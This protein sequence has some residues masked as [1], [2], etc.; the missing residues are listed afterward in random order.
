LA[1]ADLQIEAVQILHV[2]ALEAL[3]VVVSYGIQAASTQLLFDGFRV[4]RLDGKPVPLHDGTHRSASP[5]TTT[6]A[7][8]RRCRKRIGW[9]LPKNGG[10][11]VAHVHH[12]A[13]PVV[14]PEL[15]PHQRRIEC[16]FLLRL[17]DPERDVI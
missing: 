5:A 7:G 2:K 9:H 8:R 17:R 11:P 6:T 4:P 12:N 1:I 3:A 16:R 15:P 14:A 10:T 13:R